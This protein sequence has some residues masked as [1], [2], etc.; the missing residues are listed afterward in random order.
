MKAAS[1]RLTCFLLAVVPFLMAADGEDPLR[2]VRVHVPHGNL[3]AIDL[4]GGRYVPMSAAEFEAAMARLEKR[5]SAAEPLRGATPLLDLVRYDARLIASAGTFTLLGTATWTVDSAAAAVPALSLGT[6]A[7]QDAQ[8]T[9]GAGTGDA[10]VFGRAD[11][12]LAIS[13]PQPGTYSCQW[14]C[15]VTRHA[16]DSL[17]L[18]LPL[19]PALVTTIDIDL[20]AAVRPLVVGETGDTPLQQALTVLAQAV[21]KVGLGV[22]LR[23]GL[24]A[25]GFGLRGFAFF[26]AFCGFGFGLFF[27]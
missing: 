17:S 4:G 14:Q 26:F 5:P 25:G 22:G 2:F 7:V 9:T 10:V 3:S 27:A 12:S 11:G 24:F 1:C 13:T 21:G 23:F 19:V 8:M 15:P 20:P 16:D 18:V 6:L